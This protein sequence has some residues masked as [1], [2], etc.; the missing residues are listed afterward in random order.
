MA[1]LELAEGAVTTSGDYER[2]IMVHGKRYSHLLDPRTGW[3]VE[4][5]QS[6]SVIAPIAV[7]AGSASTI[8]MLKGNEGSAWLT[9]LGL[10]C[11]WDDEDGRIGQLD[12]THS[13]CSVSMSKPQPG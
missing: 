5:L 13:R 9:E 6:V 7:I 11:L 10:P 1:H 2:A 8:A 12:I 3:P 4:G